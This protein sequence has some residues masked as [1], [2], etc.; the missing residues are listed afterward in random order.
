M[1]AIHKK[2]DI[3][4]ISKKNHAR[5]VSQGNLQ[6]AEKP[7]SANEI[8]RNLRQVNRFLSNFPKRPIASH[9]VYASIRDNQSAYALECLDR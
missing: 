5:S 7:M 8:E 6:Q 1:A 9:S 2:P 4:P 3:V